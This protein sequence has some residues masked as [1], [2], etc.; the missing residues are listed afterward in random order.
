MKIIIY[1]FV[2]AYF[3]MFSSKNVL[4]DVPPPPPPIWYIP[5]DED[6]NITADIYFPDTIRWYYMGRHVTPNPKTRLGAVSFNVPG[7]CEYSYK[8]FDKNNKLIIEESGRSEEYG[9][10]IIKCKKSFKFPNAAR[11]ES[12]D[13]VIKFSITLHRYKKDRNIDERNKKDNN[14]LSSD[15]EKHMMNIIGRRK[16]YG[17]KR[18]K[19]SLIDYNGEKFSGTKNISISNN[20]FFESEEKLHR[21]NI[22]I[23]GKIDKR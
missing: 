7:P 9:R 10:Q 18:I 23:P 1:F 13:Y 14:K 19:Y 3:C 2:F 21:H 17:D 12:L 8:L 11:N 6:K 5:F 22:M 15:S 4:A 16:S 20:I